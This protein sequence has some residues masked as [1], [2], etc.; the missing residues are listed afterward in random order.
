MH[1]L[2]SAPRL[3]DAYGLNTTC[4]ATVCSTVDAP[5]GASKRCGLLCEMG[6]AC[7]LDANSM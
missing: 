4:L 1:E 7:R 3:I 6:S 2:L 5:R